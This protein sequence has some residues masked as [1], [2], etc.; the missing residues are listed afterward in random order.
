MPKLVDSEE[1]RRLIRRAARRVFARRGLAGTGLAQVARAARMGRSS[2]YHYYPDKASLVHDLA[3]EIL[4]D[5]RSAFAV[6]ARASGS[7]RERIERLAVALARVV[8]ESATMGRILLELCSR[9][10]GR[11]RPLFRDL[12]R[13][14]AVV[15]EEGQTLGEFDTT[16]TPELT[17]A[18]VIGA[19]DG[20]LL[21]KLVDP[22]AFPDPEGLRGAVVHTVH[23]LVAA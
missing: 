5:E 16:C 1:Q 8:E 3:H 15:I 10:A 4:A 18:L 17:S 19:I 11:L 9:E 2:L 14:L 6:A 23:K 13:D 12:R 7:P 21:Q 20:L 22:S